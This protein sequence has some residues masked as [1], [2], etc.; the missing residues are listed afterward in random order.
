METEARSWMYYC[1]AITYMAEEIYFRII[2]ILPYRI[3][4]LLELISTLPDV[5]LLIYVVSPY[6]AYRT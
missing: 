4:R 6:Q 3:S 1:T 2:Y 5:Y